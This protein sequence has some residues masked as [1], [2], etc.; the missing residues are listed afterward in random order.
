[1]E[2][3]YTEQA[4]EDRAFWKDSGKKSIQKKIGELI[5]SI[6]ETPFTGIGK[7]EALKHKYAGM[8]SRRINS[9]HRLIYEV[10]EEKIFI[11]AMHGHYTN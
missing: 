7:P 11:H 3:V 9:E 2:I 4:Q 8:W 5:D 6:K 1:M 10:G